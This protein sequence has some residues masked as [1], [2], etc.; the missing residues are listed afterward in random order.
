PQGNASSADF[1]HDEPWLA[2]N[3][4]QSGHSARDLANHAMI[5]RDY[6]RLPTKPCMDAEACYE[7]HAVNWDAANGYFDDY[8]I[9]K[10]AYW[11]LFAGAHGHT[12]GANGV[13]QFWKGEGEGDRFGV[14]L[15]WEEALDL[16]G[17]GQMRFVRRLLESRPLLTRVPDQ[18]MLASRARAGGEHVRATRGEDGAYAFVYLPTGGPVAVDL[19]KLSGDT[20]V[21]TWYDPRTGETHAA[22]ERPKTGAATFEPPTSGPGNDW[23]LVLDDAARRFPPPG[24]AAA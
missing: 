8:D 5:E 1:F 10:T 4:I 11:P 17:A 7:D 3:M 23:I 21:A 15:R 24:S 20:V 9:R 14:R 2:F 13:F 19:G 12:Y 6:R 16:P 22:G 18:G